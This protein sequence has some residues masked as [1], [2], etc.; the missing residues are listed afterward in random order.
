MKKLFET[1]DMRHV[2][3]I[4]KIPILIIVFNLLVLF[5]LHGLDFA[6]LLVS[7]VDHLVLNIRLR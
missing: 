3:D 6:A 2:I 7:S 4:S 5:Q 1:L